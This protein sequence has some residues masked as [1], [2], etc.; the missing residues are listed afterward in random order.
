MQVSAAQPLCSA[1]TLDTHS[2]SAQRKPWTLFG[3]KPQPL[4][5]ARSLITVQP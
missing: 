1:Y 5:T 4:L 2:R 3:P